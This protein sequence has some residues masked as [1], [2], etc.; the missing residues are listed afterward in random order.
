MLALLTV[1][2]GTDAAGPGPVTQVIVSMASDTMATGDTRNLFASGLDA[3][4]TVVPGPVSWSVSDTSIG[5]VS[6]AGALTAHGYGTLTVTAVIAGVTGQAV[7]HVRPLIA[8]GPEFPSLFAGDTIHLTATAH[9]R[10]SQP[11][12]G[13]PALVS[14]NTGIATV[15]AGIVTAVSAGLVTIV[16]NLGGRSESLVV[17]VIARPA[18]TNGPIMARCDGFNRV[19]V[20]YGATIDTISPPG[21]APEEH[22]WSPD[23]TRVA[24]SYVGTGSQRRGVWVSSATGAGA[25]EVAPGGRDPDWSPDGAW[26]VL[27]DANFKQSV[28]RANGF[29]ARR[30]STSI[31]QEQRAK[32]SPD[33]RRIA[34]L[35]DGAVRIVP[36]AGGAERTVTVPGLARHVFWS[37]D[38]RWLAVSALISGGGEGVWLIRPDGTGLRPF[39]PNCGPGPTCNALS[40]STRPMWSRDGTRIVSWFE[41][42]GIGYHAQA[43]ADG[44]AIFTC[45][46]AGLAFPDWSPDGQRLHFIDYNTSNGTLYTALVDCTDL[47]PIATSVA[48]P[49]RWRP[50][51]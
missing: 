10:Q 39:S 35:R 5:S 6:A 49:A 45:L 9:N 12:A 33:G 3:A 32:W 51:P 31:L 28:V 18:W 43:V 29:G 48:G 44:N 11:I 16:A 4:G 24:I 27:E 14:R 41:Q 26:L 42:G 19:C 7:L 20:F 21:E 47:V 36:F 40:T 34:F 1:S 13:A 17:A 8:L 25:I 22:E 38:G 23:G 2:C 46:R 30:L 15:N 50:G 37:P